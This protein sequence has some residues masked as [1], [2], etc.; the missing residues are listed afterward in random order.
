MRLVTFRPDDGRARAG[1]LFGSTVIDL[2]AAAPLVFE[3]AEQLRWDL[4]SLL[5]GDNDTSI[6]AAET[7]SL[8]VMDQLGAGIGPADDVSPGDGLSDSAPIGS[9]SIG[10]AEMLLPLDAV[11]LLAPLPFPPSLR[12][13]SSFEQQAAAR[14]QHLGGVPSTWYEGPAFTFGNSGAVLGPG[15]TLSMP[16]TRALDY[17]LQLACV[18]GRPTRDVAAEDAADYIAGY[19]ILNGWV[20]RDLERAELELGFGAKSRDFAVS[21]GPWLVTPDEIEELA[22]PD[23]RH[24]L[25][26]VARVNGVER[27]RGNPRDSFY[28][29]GDL[30]AHASAGVTL[31]PGDIIATGAVGGGS[32]HDLSGGAGP[33]LEPGDLV[34]LVVRGLGTLSNQVV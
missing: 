26:M 8:A 19:T 17:E 16:A 23:G 6:E 2:E 9:L 11:R 12:M 27:S 7:I 34:E 14:F 32:L 29:I 4:L 3:E 31:A 20:A 13:F 30:I 22:L 21:L 18:I 24:N 25:T 15:A 33:W 1:V 28:T 10:G 5:R